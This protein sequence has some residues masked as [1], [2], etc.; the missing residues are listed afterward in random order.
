MEV[1]DRQ[2]EPLHLILVAVWLHPAMAAHMEQVEVDLVGLHIVP[3][4]LTEPPQEA[5]S[6]SYGPVTLAHSHQ[7]ALDRLNFG[8]ENELIH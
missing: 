8:V 5:Q 6:V 2:V 7:L 1:E 3:L 4:I